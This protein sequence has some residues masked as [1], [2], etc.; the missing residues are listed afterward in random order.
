MSLSFHRATRI[1]PPDLKERL[2]RDMMRARQSGAQRTLTWFGAK[3]TQATN[4]AP[5][6]LRQR[7]QWQ[8]ETVAGWKQ[9]TKLAC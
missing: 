7:E 1:A 3:R 5:E 2:K 6:S 9:G 8:M 4:G